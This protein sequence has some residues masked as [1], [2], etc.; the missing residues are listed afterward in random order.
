[1]GCLHPIIDI[2]IASLAHDWASVSR[3]PFFMSRAPAACLSLPL[4]RGWS[5]CLFFGVCSTA[6]T[7]PYV[8][9]VPS[10]KLGFAWG[11]LRGLAKPPQ[12]RAAACNG[13][14]ESAAR[15]GRAA[16]MIQSPRSPI[17]ELTRRASTQED[18]EKGRWGALLHRPFPCPSLRADG[19]F[20]FGLDIFGYYDQRCL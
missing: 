8:C 14:D 3:V 20:G 11:C 13:K 10:A 7:N 17:A 6:T 12:A 16:E 19:G 4:I 2:P 1:M 5:S 9:R 15:F 18:W